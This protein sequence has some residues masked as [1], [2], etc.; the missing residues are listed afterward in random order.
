MFCRSVPSS[1]GSAVGGSSRPDLRAAAVHL[2]R[3]GVRRVSKAF[4]SFFVVRDE[5]VVR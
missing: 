3:V 5:V 2:P 4:L 1:L